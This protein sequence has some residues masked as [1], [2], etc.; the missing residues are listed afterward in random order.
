MPFDFTQ[1]ATILVCPESK[2]LLVIDE[3]SL[4]CLDPDC[5]LN[6][7]IR[8]GIP[9]MLVEEARQLSFADWGAIMKKQGR[10]PVSGEDPEGTD[11]ALREEPEPSEES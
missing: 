10:D 7:E 5:R 2:S 6:Y 8:D 11:A 9:I 3:Q 4:I 1:L